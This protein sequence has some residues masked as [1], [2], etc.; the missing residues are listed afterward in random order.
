LDGR[1]DG[2]I[3]AA[4]PVTV[5]SWLHPPRLPMSWLLT[6]VAN[7]ARNPRQVG[8]GV[9]SAR[10]S[11]PRVG[12]GARLGGR[13]LALIG[14]PPWPAGQRDMPAGVGWSSSIG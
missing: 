10:S 12:P 6:I 13:A 14:R 3:M 2:H 4:M 5:F 9:V 7:G 11:W 8:G 1:L